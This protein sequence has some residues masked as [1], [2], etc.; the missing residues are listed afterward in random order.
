MNI[1]NSYEMCYSNYLKNQVD[2]LIKTAK[3]LRK[4]HRNQIKQHNYLN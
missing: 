1:L 4:L 3:E 2:I